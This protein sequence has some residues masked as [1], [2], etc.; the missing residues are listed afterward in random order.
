LP[1]ESLLKTLFIL[2]TP[3]QQTIIA[4]NNFYPEREDHLWDEAE[5]GLVANFLRSDLP[6]KLLPNYENSES[7]Q[8][9][10]RN[11]EKS[12]IEIHPEWQR[13]DP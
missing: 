10:R 9:F 7:L 3:D 1:P 6:W 13:L 5:Y 4:L 2:P 8:T 11:F 12:M